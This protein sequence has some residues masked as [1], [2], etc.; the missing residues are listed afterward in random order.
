MLNG[1]IKYQKVLCHDKWK[2]F[3]KYTSARSFA[4]TVSESGW[5]CTRGRAKSIFFNLKFNW[6]ENWTVEEHFISAVEWLK[7]YP[8]I[9]NC[10]II[11]ICCS[12]NKSLLKMESKEKV[13]LFCQQTTSPYESGDSISTITETT[14]SQ[15]HALL[16]SDSLAIPP[17]QVCNFFQ[18]TCSCNRRV[19]V[20]SSDFILRIRGSPSV[21]SGN[22]L[23][24][25][26]LI[27]WSLDD[28]S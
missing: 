27:K 12:F 17:P 16:T 1:T 28:P 24:D 2:E 15:R 11:Y 22:S 7:D 6:A 4:P 25:R 3:L 9:R 13:A 14:A 19:F 23:Q 18:F 10:Y 21:T 5:P 20:L 26:W 8:R